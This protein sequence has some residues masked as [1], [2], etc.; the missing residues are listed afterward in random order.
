VQPGETRTYEGQRVAQGNG[1][2]EDERVQALQAWNQR[3]SAF[4]RE[5]PGTALLCA[6]ALGFVVGKI[7]SRR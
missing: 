7:A 5:N 3:A 1:A 4:V 2:R 6:V